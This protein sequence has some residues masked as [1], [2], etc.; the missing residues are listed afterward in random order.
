MCVTLLYFSNEQFYKNTMLIFAQN[1]KKYKN[2]PSLSR[3]TK[4]QNLSS[5]CEQNSSKCRKISK[6]HFASCL[7]T[8]NC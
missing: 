1:L 4:S 7:F 5:S 6:V 2:N 8:Y 3:R